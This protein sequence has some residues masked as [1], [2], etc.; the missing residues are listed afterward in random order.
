VRYTAGV[1]YLKVIVSDSDNGRVQVDGA[2]L[3]G[4]TN[5]EETIENLILNRTD[6]SAIEQRLLDPDIDIEDYFD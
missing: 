5:L 1:E 4:E 6:I 3:I 2:V